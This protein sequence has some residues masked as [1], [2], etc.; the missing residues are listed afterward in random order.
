[1]KKFLLWLMFFVIF[2]TPSMASEQLDEANAKF[3]YK[4][5]P[6]HPFLVG[7]FANWI[8][9]KRPPMIVTVD[10]SAAFDTNEYRQ[11]AV[12]KTYDWWF[13]EKEEMDGE[14]RIYEAFHYLLLGKL[15]DGTHVIQTAS[16]GGGSGFFMDLMFVRFSEGEI[17]SEGKKEKQL[18]M[19]IVGSY[20]LGDRYNGVIKVYPGKVFIPVSDGQFGSGSIDKDV[21]LKFPKMKED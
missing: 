18:L 9:D 15:A 3:T 14:T 4:G 12:K 10:V 11:S 1:M 2:I 19:S 17:F 8:S 21:E 5:K 6:I 20:I 13:S 16:S 7:K